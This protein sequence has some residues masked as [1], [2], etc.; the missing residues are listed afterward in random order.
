MLQGKG[1]DSHF[2][3]GSRDIAN[4]KEHDESFEL[5]NQPTK[6]QPMKQNKENKQ[7]AITIKQTD[8]KTDRQTDRETDRQIS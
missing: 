2:L 4:W 5:S 1:N 7:Q 3:L 8:R 6:H